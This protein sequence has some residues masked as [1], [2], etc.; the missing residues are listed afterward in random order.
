[1]ELRT[2]SLFQVT[3]AVLAWAF[4]LHRRRRR[5]ASKE[6][7]SPLPPGPRPLPLIGNFLDIGTLPHQ[8]CA[9]LAR[10]YGPIMTIHLGAV[11]TV[12]ISSAAAAQEMFKQHDAALAGRY[13][14]EAINLKTGNEGSV[15][16]AQPGPRWRALRRLQNTMF[17][18]PSRLEAMRAVR[19][20]CVDAL[21]RRITEASAGGTRPVNVG[22]L[23][24]LTTFDHIGRIALSR[25]VLLDSDWEQAGGA[26]LYHASQIMELMGKPNSAD[27]VPSLRKLDPQ[28][29]K[30]RMEFHIG[31]ML[32]LVS[33]FVLER[34]AEGFREDKKKDF[35]DMLL[36]FADDQVEEDTKLS[37]TAIN[38]NIVETLIAGTDSSGGTMEWAM[39]ELLHKPSTLKKVQDELRRAIPRG[40]KI[41][42]EDVVELPYLNAV[43]KETLR[44]HPPVP[45]LIPH[46]S[47]KACTVLGYHIPQ[48]TQI[49]VNSWGI[50]REEKVWD[51]PDD[52][53]PERFIKDGGID[54]KGNHF[55]FIPF[56]AGRRI[57]PGIP[58]VQRMLPL[59]L[60][61]M[62]YSF[63]WVLPDG[64][65][66]E[67]MDMRER[68]GTTLRKAV[69]LS[70]VPVQSLAVDHDHN[71]H[72]H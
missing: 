27:Y 59:V 45:F 35:L 8:S 1:M 13:V 61:T 15:I 16:T 6:K 11:T 43:I 32:H 49:F 24:F 2:P 51:D 17:F 20:G 55:H 5:Q 48:D 10:K 18:T 12:V 54:Y 14:Y 3:L 44:M 68:L 19:A 7:P 62:L 50:G 69:Q 22:R 66:A 72:D 46:K 23:M 36:E 29:I 58:L 40:K 57:C 41:E 25:D 56:G 60:G 34:N 42:E 31:N 65:R 26:F 53:Q 71:V 37:P 47:T 67:D 52:F 39:S 38:I 28:G 4:L 30:K 70:A 33:A 63:D 64:M 9:Q 21:M